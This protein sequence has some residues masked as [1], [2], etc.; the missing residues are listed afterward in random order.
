M[1][2]EHLKKYWSA[3]MAAWKLMKSYEMVTEQH[4][5]QMMEIHNNT[6]FNRLFC[7]AIWQEIK[8]IRSGGIP[9][10]SKQYQDAL[11]DVWHMFKAFSDPTDTEQY[12][13]DLVNDISRISEKFGNSYFILNLLVYVTLEELERIYKINY[14]KTKKKH[15]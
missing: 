2:E 13:N 3:Y 9:L 5:S 6:V 4:I 12:W 14:G 11:N 15:V 1:S 10:E 8:R 7:L